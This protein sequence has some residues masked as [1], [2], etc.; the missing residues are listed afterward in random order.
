MITFGTLFPH[1]IK[2]MLLGSG[3]LGKNILIAL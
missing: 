2:V 1:V 3:K